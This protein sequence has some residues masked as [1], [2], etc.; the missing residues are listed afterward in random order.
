M[1]KS[2]RHPARERRSVASIAWLLAG[3]LLLG[4]CET[5]GLAGPGGASESRA[6]RLA[7]DGRHAD[8]A[9]AYMGLATGAA[10]PERDRLTLLAVEQFLD[11]GDVRRAATA[12]A[13]VPRPAS[14][15]LL[16]LWTTNRAT[17]DLYNGKA[18]DALALL[19]PLTREP[20]SRRDRL[21]AEALRAD[22]WF[23][24]QDPARAVALMI[25]RETWI[26]DE[27][28]IELNRKR[29]WQG[30]LVS[31]PQVLRGA[32]D[33]ALDPIARGWLTIGSIAASTGQQGVG[34]NNGVVRWR[35]ANPDHPALTVLGEL[36][37]PET[38]LLEYPRQVALLLPLS[39]AAADA[40]KAI[41]N[42]FL[43][44]YFATASGLDDRQNVRIYDVNSE[45][46]AS[47]AYAT[48]VA[49]GA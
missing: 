39:G 46:G 21:R 26:R 24:K 33:L 28:G 43:G 32:A 17:F 30:L 13:A 41:Q 35:D 45:G 19:E 25:Q 3:V 2:L 27:R 20:L 48:A 4:G 31:N 36:Q 15:N 5:T 14:G 11:A 37:L 38:L 6:E 44:A 12:F 9:G 23:Q 8:A 34:W 40:G 47:S 16:P 22:A 29:L 7:E 18:D 10:G 42:G 1:I 49:D